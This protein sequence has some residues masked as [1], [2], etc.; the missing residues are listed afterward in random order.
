[1]SGSVAKRFALGFG[2]GTPA[3]ATVVEVYVMS[4][5]G[6][7]RLSSEELNSTGPKGPGEALPLAVA[8]A[9]HNPIG[10]I[11]SRAAHV[12]GEV[13]RRITLDGSAERTAKESGEGLKGGAQH[14]GWI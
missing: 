5:Q 8:V 3:L 4:D 12:P 1:D 13:S 10:L 2:S 9:R 6:L 7:R 14:Q 11:V